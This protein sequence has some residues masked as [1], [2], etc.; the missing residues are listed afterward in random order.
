MMMMMM[1]MMMIVAADLIFELVVVV[2][3]V[4]MDPLVWSAVLG[5]HICHS[6]IIARLRRDIARYSEIMSK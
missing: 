6:E 5:A 1:M 2:G 3:L 4:A